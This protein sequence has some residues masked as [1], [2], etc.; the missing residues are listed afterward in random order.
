MK[1]LVLSDY[2]LLDKNCDKIKYL[3]SKISG[4]TNSIN[5]DFGK[6]R[7]DLYNSFPIKTI[8]IFHNVIILMKSVVNKNKNKCYCNIVF[9]KCSYKYKCQ[10]QYFQMNVCV[11]QMLYYDRIDVSEG[12][13]FNKIN[14][15]KECNICQHWYK[16]G[17][18]TN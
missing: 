15:S 14:T 1:Y 16:K 8:L 3:I 2:G 7:I 10:K 11:L 18:V 13:D 9:E 17:K 4:L 5:H 12:I 6:I